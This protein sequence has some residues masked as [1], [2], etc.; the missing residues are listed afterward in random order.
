MMGLSANVLVILQLVHLLAFSIGMLAFVRSELGTIIQ[1]WVV[2]NVLAAGFFILVL[3][4]GAELN[5]L[6]FTLP[7]T[8]NL[9][10]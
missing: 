2:S 7:N 5:F 6:N 4:R 1:Y 3:F 10:H 8:L 9:E